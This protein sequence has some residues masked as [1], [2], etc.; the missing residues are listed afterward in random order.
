MKTKSIIIYGVCLLTLSGI[1][2]S[3]AINTS[4]SNSRTEEYAIVD[5]IQSG[6]RKYIRVTRGT[7]PTTETEWKKEKTGDRDDFT[8]IITELNQLNEQG[9][10]LLN[11]S[12]A[13]QTISG[14][15]VTLYGDA[16]HTFMMIKKVK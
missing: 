10:E 7:E 5:V 9:F 3:Y 6:K 16:R 14:G 4:M 8:P 11:A 15:N 13:Y 12:L 2:S 1:L